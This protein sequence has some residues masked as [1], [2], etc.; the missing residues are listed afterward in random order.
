MIKCPKC[1]A[2]NMIGA[3][4]CRTCSG[5]LELNELTP[6]DI[7]EAQQGNAGE[8]FGKIAYRLLHAVI[9]VTL[10]SILVGLCLPESGVVSGSLEGKDLDRVK[11]LYKKFRGT[12]KANASF[13]LSNLEATLA[14]NHALGLENLDPEGKVVTM[15]VTRPMPGG[16]AMSPEYLSVCFLGGN[17]VRFILKTTLG[18]KM[19]LYSSVIGT[20]DA[21]AGALIFRPISVKHGKLPLPGA[22]HQVVLGRFAALVSGNP[23]LERLQKT[24]KE[25]DIQDGSAKFT[26]V[27]K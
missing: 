7:R 1:G 12:K 16:L 10:V 25:L 8:R 20:V 22:L 26:I 18:G 2:D 21:S 9:I 3:I 11:S 4:F 15:D 5:K 24:V 13:E 17:R 6:D 27:R 19:T 23:D 14:A